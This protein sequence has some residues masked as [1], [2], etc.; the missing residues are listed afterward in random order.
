MLNNTLNR[1]KI[2][3]FNFGSRGPGFSKD[4][5][6][7]IYGVLDVESIFRKGL[8]VITDVNEDVEHAVMRD[9]DIMDIQVPSVLLRN[10]EKLA[11]EIHEQYRDLV[12]EEYEY[13]LAKGEVDSK[14]QQK[15][16]GLCS[17]KDLSPELK[18]SNIR[19]ALSIPKKLDMIGCEIAAKSDS[20]AA[21]TENDFEENEVLN[22]AIFEHQEWCEEKRGTGWTYG[23]EKDEK[24]RISPYLV[25]WDELDE[26]TKQVDKDAIL[27]IPYLLDCVGLKIVRTKN[28]DA[29]L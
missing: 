10:V 29:H 2:V 21:I 25:S 6:E 26:D 3:Y 4:K 23:D 18:M 22:L 8:S 1:L 7:F 20:R 5:K 28:Q 27:K 17:F 16:D 11:I 9:M 14:L 24:R 13:K 12:T 19:Q 15:Y